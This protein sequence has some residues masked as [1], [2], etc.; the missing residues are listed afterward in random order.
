MVRKGYHLSKEHCRKIGEA[1]KIALKGRVFSDEHRLHLSLAGRGEKNSNYNHFIFHK[2]KSDK[3]YL[4]GK[5]ISIGNKNICSEETKRKM[6]IAHKGIYFSEIH[7][8]RLSLA[9]KGEIFSEERKRKI[10]EKRALQKHCWTTS[11]EIKTQAFLRELDIE[12]IPHYYISDITLPYQCDIY[13]PTYNL[14]IEC[15]GIQYH[16]Y[17]YGTEKD[18]I[19]TKEIMDKGYKVLRLWEYDIRHMNIETF[20]WK[21]NN[22]IELL[23]PT[24]IIE[25]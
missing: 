19:R 1:N 22:S 20:E 12:F 10:R 2:K 16:N 17:P 4:Q 25:R 5:K 18:H 6:S 8:K 3:D 15:D 11:I 21:L 9:N 7:K 14:I 24:C 23:Y 13:V